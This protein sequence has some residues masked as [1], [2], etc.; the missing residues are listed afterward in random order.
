MASPSVTNTF[1]NSTTAD[2]TQVNTNFTDLINSLTDGTKDLSI[3][4]LTLSGNATLNGNV[5]IGSASNDDL[6]VNASLASSIVIKTQ[7][8][9]DVGTSALGLRSIYIAS[10][11]SAGRGTRILG[12]VV[13]T[14]NTLTLPILSGTLGFH[15]A[16]VASQTTTYP[17]TTTDY[18]V[19]LSGA[20]GAFSATLPTAVGATGK[21]YALKRTDSTIANVVTVAT[22][23]SQTIDGITTTTLNTQYEGIKVISDGSNWHV[24]DRIIPTNVTSYTPTISAGFGTAASVTFNYA[25]IKNYL[26]ITGGFTA[27]TVASSSGT[28]TL[29]SGAVLDTSALVGPS[30]SAVVRS[31]V[32]RWYRNTATATLTRSGP[33]LA[34]NNDTGTVSFTCDDYDVAASP[35]SPPNVSS[36]LS[37]S[38]VIYVE[39]TVPISGWKG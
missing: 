15:P 39:F 17:I 22:T 21:I 12:G 19:P 5:T 7:N 31:I 38:D 4:A 24:L 6:T 35:F 1:A 32:G 27:G 23:S 10:S 29:P 25:R 2:A 26:K 9:F 33:L 3:A 30:I 37:S 28:I 36:F 13:A 20:S 18:F 11:D 14:N 16:V 8:S 34:L